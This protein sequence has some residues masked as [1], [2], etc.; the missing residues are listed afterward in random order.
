M[1]IQELTAKVTFIGEGQL[2]TKLVDIHTYDEMKSFVEAFNTMADKIQHFYSELEQKV[3]ERTHLL[4]EANVQLL[5]QGAALRAI[6][7]MV[8]NIYKARWGVELFFRWIKQNLNVPRLFGT[9]KNAV[10]NQLFSALLVYVILKFIHTS[11]S[12][13]IKQEP[14]SL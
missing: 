12:K 5:E 10:Y 3:N 2:E 11:I 4:Q 8:A 13:R 7:E 14:L 9:T 6:A 1:P